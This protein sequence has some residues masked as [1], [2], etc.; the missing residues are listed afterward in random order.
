VSFSP[1]EAYRPSA[2]PW[3][4]KVPEHWS[5]AAL[6][7]RFQVVGGSTPKSDVQEYWEGNIPWATPTDLGGSRI[8][9]LKGTARLITE[10]GLASC[11]TTVVPE[12]SIVL[13]TRAPIGSLAIA[14]VPLCTNQGCRALVPTDNACA[15]YF[16]YALSV[17]TT[18]LNVRGRGSTFL[19]LSADELG[20]FQVPMP[21]KAEQAL[22]AVFL[23]RETANID[24]LV[25]EQ[26]R[27]IEL[28]EE[29]R[30][31]VISYAVTK[32]LNPHVPMK[33][34]GVE[35]L[36]DV[37]AHWTLPPLYLRYEQ[38]LGKMLD[39]GKMT[40]THQMPYLR[41]VDVRWDRVEV[42]DLPTMDIAP[43]E[44]DRFSVRKGDLLTVEGRD[45]GRSAIWEGADG[46]VAYQKALHRLRP[47][48]AAEHTRFF[49]YT[50]VFAHSRGV[51]MADQLPNEIPHLT[52]EELRRYRFPTP[53]ILEQ[54]ALSAFLDV[55][56]RRLDA[57][58]GA[59]E[60]ALRLLR[61]RRIGL[62]SAAVTG[63]IDVRGLAPSGSVAS[64]NRVNSMASPT[65]A[66]HTPRVP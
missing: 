8:P 33:P 12:G 61:E 21:P 40:G 37:P 48:S 4:G 53:P 60:Q 59:S 3:I 50:M 51:F 2:V 1:Y 46:A 23:D 58:V 52:G 16:A 6:K 19:E 28:L 15:R 49:Y 42:D 13:S 44:R 31:A 14:G 36:G 38:A 47:L 57:L 43:H 22:I 17:C 41:N 54:I 9:T 18:E 25:A 63:Q 35:W 20:S 26:E 65:K 5:V 64:P 30:Q 32:G 29:K 24:A 45:L 56:T 27:L 55:Q 11:G 66:P 10:S 34:S 62:I 7:R 39:H